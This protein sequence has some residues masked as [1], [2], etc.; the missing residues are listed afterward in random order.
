VPLEGP[1]LEVARQRL[2][3]PGQ[4]SDFLFPGVAGKAT[5]FPKRAW[6]TALRKSGID[7]LRP[8]DLR[9]THG[10]YLGM[11]GKTLP[12]IMEALGH[13]TPAVALRYIHIADSHKQKVSA[14]VNAKLNDWMGNNG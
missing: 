3:T 4:G 7:N 12:E 8:H 10:S 1:G 9:H 2:A 11:L 5:G 14:E 13:K 6:S